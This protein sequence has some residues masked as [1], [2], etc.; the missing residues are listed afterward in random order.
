MHTSRIV[1]DR[2]MTSSIDISANR[3]ARKWSKRE[4]VRRA[5]WGFLSP[6]LFSW[7]PRH[8][9]GWRRFILRIFGA[10]VGRSVHV[11]PSVKITIPWNLSI[12]DHSAVGDCAIL[13]AL[14]PITLGERVTISQYAHLCAG[15]H[16]YTDTTMPLMKP[17]INI[18]DDAWICADA[19]VGPAVVI[20]AGAI[21]A[22]RGVVVRDVPSGAIVGGNPATLIKQRPPFA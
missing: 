17:P 20:G 1:F 5:L 2:D 8:L 22:A 19:F 7:T 18:G 9:W 6:P 14:G 3:R 4:L 21:V 11:Y 16:D 10:H 15:S 13:Y 12:G